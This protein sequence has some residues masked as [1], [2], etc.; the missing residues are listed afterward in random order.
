M[1]VILLYIDGLVLR[2]N[3]LTLPCKANPTPPSPQVLQSIKMTID[4]YARSQDTLEV[5]LARARKTMIY[6]AQVRNSQVQESVAK[7]MVMAEMRRLVRQGSRAS[8]LGDP[9]ELALRHQLVKQG[10][11]VSELG[12]F[13]SPLKKRGSKASMDAV[14]DPLPH[15]SR[16]HTEGV[17]GLAQKRRTAR[18]KKVSTNT[19]F[20]VTIFDE[21]LK[22]LAALSQEHSVLNPQL[23]LSKLVT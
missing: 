18:K 9:M 7:Q 3:G 6:L 5:R 15:R 10:S 14:E 4:G 11:L 12:D 17:K 2:R 23:Y 22:E 20:A 19:L 21:F 1:V 8:E 16:A 13:P